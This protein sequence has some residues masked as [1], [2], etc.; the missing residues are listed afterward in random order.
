MLSAIFT[1]L[2][3]FLS[4][5]SGVALVRRSQVAKGAHIGG[6]SRFSS[7]TIDKGSYTGRSCYFYKTNIGKFCSISDSVVCGLPE[8]DATY[9]STSP[10]FNKGKNVTKLSYGT[11]PR[12][13]HPNTAI[14]NDVWIGANVTIKA[15]VTVGDGAV[16]GMGSIVTKDIPPYAIVA[17]V[18]AKI[19]RYRFDEETVAKLQALQWWNWDEET[20]KAHGNRFDDPCELLKQWEENG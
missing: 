18:P 5:R 20:L 19:I 6:G 2:I 17:G 15:G 11:L 7:S 3:S 12:P 1:S 14:G 9:V 16:I 13:V 8:H 10:V 4:G